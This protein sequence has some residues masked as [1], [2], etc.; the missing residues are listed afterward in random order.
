LTY[1][2][3]K[4]GFDPYSRANPYLA[5]QFVS[6]GGDG[7]NYLGHVK[8]TTFGGQFGVS[9]IK[10]ILFTAS[11]DISP[12]AY[13]DVHATSASKAEGAYFVG[14]GG[15]GDAIKIGPDMYRVAYGGIASP[16]T[17]SYGTDPLYTT[18]ITQGMVDRRSAG[19]SYK[20][21][22]V[23]T[24]QTKQLRLYAS[25]AWFQY[26]NE[27][28]HN[29]TSEFNVDGTY[30]FNKVRQGAYKGFLAR[31]R[32]APRQQVATPTTPQRFE[33]QRF[34]TEYDF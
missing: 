25:E 34:M 9:P 13:A 10:N 6:E 32:I 8:N 20:T 23:F 30:Y 29:L 19:N 1:L 22:V 16:Y 5:T 12:W 2:E 15:T 18:M 24:N 17:D 14:G 31:V 7:L 4:F 33:Y 28:L 26:S 3:G 11:T 27:T 21:A